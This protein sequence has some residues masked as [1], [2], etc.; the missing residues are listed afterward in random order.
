MGWTT[1]TDWKKDNTNVVSH[2]FA[3]VFPHSILYNMVKKAG[4]MILKKHTENTRHLI[5]PRGKYTVIL[6]DSKVCS[7]NV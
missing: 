3:L 7:V 5:E 6:E 1:M 4:V 2:S